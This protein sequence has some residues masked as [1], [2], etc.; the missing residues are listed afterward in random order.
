MSTG[1]FIA[2]VSTSPTVGSDANAP[3]SRG[4]ASVMMATSCVSNRGWPGPQLSHHSGFGWNVP[5][6]KSF[7]RLK[8]GAVLYVTKTGLAGSKQCEAVRNTVDDNADPEQSVMKFG[9]TASN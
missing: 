8:G 4:A 5:C 6:V 9:S 1:V 2:S 3:G 7:A